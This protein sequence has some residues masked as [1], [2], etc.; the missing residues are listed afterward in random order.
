LGAIF[1]AL[2]GEKLRSQAPR[3][4][5]QHEAEL[6]DSS[7]AVPGEIALDPEVVR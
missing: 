6:A 3:S 7:G 2:R 1:S 4:L 5:L